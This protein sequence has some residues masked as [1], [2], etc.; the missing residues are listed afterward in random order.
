[1]WVIVMDESSRDADEWARKN[2][3]AVLSRLASV[4]QARIAQQLG[5]NESTISRW[6]DGD[7]ARFCKFLALLGV[8]VT[9]IEYKCY[10]EKTLQAVLTFAQQRMSQLNAV[11]HLAWEDE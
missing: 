2:E 6:K 10:D 5:V 11:E 9:P 8:K 4:G 3:R 7:I 1:M